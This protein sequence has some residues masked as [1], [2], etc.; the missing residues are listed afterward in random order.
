MSGRRLRVRGRR[1]QECNQ[2]DEAAWL[3]H[4]HLRMLHLSALDRTLSPGIY[5]DDRRR[6]ARCGRH[7]RRRIV[8][9]CPRPRTGWHCHVADFFGKVGAPWGTQ[10]LRC[11]CSRPAFRGPLFFPAS[12]RRECPR[13]K[14]S[15]TRSPDSGGSLTLSGSGL[16]CPDGSN[17]G[18]ERNMR[19]KIPFSLGV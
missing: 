6:A 14:R 11:E 2:D 10:D 16:H 12:G 8:H 17:C 13:R 1:K 15:W 3:S 7:T 4:C 18:R 9:D 5:P 19:S